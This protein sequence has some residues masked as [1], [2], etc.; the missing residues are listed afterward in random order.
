M[1]SSKQPFLLL[2]SLGL[3]IM[4]FMYGFDPGWFVNKFLNLGMAFT[5]GNGPVDLR[6]VFRALGGLYVGIAYFWMRCALVE[7]ASTK[8]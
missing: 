2:C 4:G 8:V 6:H 7:T 1:E 3:A 5:I